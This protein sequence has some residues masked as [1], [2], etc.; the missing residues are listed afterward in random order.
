MADISEFQQRL[1][2]ILNATSMENGSDT[3]DF[4][5]AQYLTD[6]LTAWNRATESRN[7]WYGVSSSIL[8]DNTEL[9]CINDNVPP[10]SP[11]MGCCDSTC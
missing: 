8:G 9:S 7:K 11:P 5:L 10:V 2:G 3:P 4:I 1:E 6:C